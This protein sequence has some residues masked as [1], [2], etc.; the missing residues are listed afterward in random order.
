MSIYLLYR[1]TEEIDMFLEQNKMTKA[2]RSTNPWV[3]VE[4]KCGEVGETEIVSQ[5]LNGS[6]A[7]DHI[8]IESHISAVKIKNVY[9]EEGDILPDEN[10]YIPTVGGTKAT[11]ETKG[12]KDTWFKI[13][14]VFGLN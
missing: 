1:Q 11:A 6:E 7:I 2:M 8:D 3:E 9:Y 5:H 14:L 4:L 12:P 10:G 13:N